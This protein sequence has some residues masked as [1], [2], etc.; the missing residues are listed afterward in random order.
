[1]LNF[2]S[3][4][5]TAVN[6]AKAMRESLAEA[7][8]DD[9]GNASLVLFHTTMGHNFG[10][11]LSAA[12]EICPE[13]AICGCTGSGIASREGVSEKLRALAVLTI[14]GNEVAVA[15][16]QGIDIGTSA[17][18]ARD[19]ARDLAERLD[20]VNMIGAFGPGLH[21]CADDIIRGIEEV[22]GPDVPIFGALAGDNAK[23]AHTWQFHDDQAWE[24]GLFLIGFADDSLEMVQ[25]AHH[26]SLPIEGKAFTVTASEHSR[27]DELD[28][29]PAW[30]ALMEHLNLPVDTEPGA[31]IAL[32]G[33]GIQLDDAAQN[34][35][36]NAYLLRAPFHLSED[37]QSFYML[38]SCP[39]GTKLVMMRRD[40]DYI[41]DGVDGLNARLAQRLA[42]R[43]PL[44]VFQADCMA[45][46]RMT[47]DQVSKD[48]IIRKIQDPV[49]GGE[50]VP[51]LGV[52]GFAEFAML[53]G[54]NTFH[55]FTTSLSAVVKKQ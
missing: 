50:N 41:F 6:S 53:A 42:G 10:Q 26:G 3:G 29:R 55:H 12:R 7:M 31:A 22:Y 54:H 13:A 18:L 8:G 49:C 1:M 52:Y 48:E 39:V 45:R 9:A 47:V 36:D 43:R 16:V 33:M 28:G 11:L 46:G 17:T 34:A 21:V 23:L 25:E 27:I 51:W 40:E 38:A 44:A 5:S 24:N 20:G 30:P 19:C 2:S 15:S 32:T 4:S 37:R 14:T 35:Y